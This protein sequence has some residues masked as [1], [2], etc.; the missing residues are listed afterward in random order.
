[1]FTL[2]VNNASTTLTCTVKAGSKTGEGT[3][4]ATVKAGDQIDVAIPAGFDMSDVTF[5]ISG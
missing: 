3:G 1:M 2:R 5:A 4:T